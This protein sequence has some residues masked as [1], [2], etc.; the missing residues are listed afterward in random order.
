MMV[1]L[2]IPVFIGCCSFKLVAL[3]AKPCFFFFFFGLYLCGKLVIFCFWVANMHLHDGLQFYYTCF[4][5]LLIKVSCLHAGE[6][7]DPVSLFDHR[8]FLDWTWYLIVKQRWF[9]FSLLLVIFVKMKCENSK[10]IYMVH[11]MHL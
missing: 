3:L 1:H 10:V 8:N 9:S 7:Y 2:V 6:L 5:T 4:Q 11:S